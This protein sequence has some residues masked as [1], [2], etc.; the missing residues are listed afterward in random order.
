MA[1]NLNEPRFDWGAIF[2]ASGVIILGTAILAFVIPPVLTILLQRGHTGYVAGNDLFRW[3]Y[4]A[5]AWALTIWQ[6]SWM[7][8]MVGD[9]I[10]DDMIFVAAITAAVLIVL[11]IVNSLIY[12]PIGSEGQ[13]LPILTSTDVGGAIILVVVALVGAGTNRFGGRASRAGRRT[14]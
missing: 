1:D 12:E 8:R 2:R 13:L 3:G 11:K 10:W 5:I 14:R 7:L 4:W 9:R 6:G